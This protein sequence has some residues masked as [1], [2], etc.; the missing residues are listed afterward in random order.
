MD[1]KKARA[2]Y[3][4][5]EEKM[6][7]MKSHTICDPNSMIDVINETTMHAVEHF[8]PAIG[9]QFKQDYVFI[10]GSALLGV[11]I[12]SGED[13]HATSF[14]ACGDIH[15]WSHHLADVMEQNPEIYQMVMHAVHIYHLNKL[16]GGRRE[17][18]F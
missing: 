7:E 5:H 12:K 2:V 18:D 13:V 10:M 16:K 3:R 1:P 9:Q 15:Q 8:S 6:A 17:K 14:F 11:D 4:Q